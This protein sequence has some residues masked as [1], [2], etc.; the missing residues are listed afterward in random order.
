M[1]VLSWKQIDFYNLVPKYFFLLENSP[2]K[3]FQLM[4]QVHIL[5]YLYLIFSIV[6]VPIS[7]HKFSRILSGY[8]IIYAKYIH[9]SPFEKIP[10]CL[11]L[12]TP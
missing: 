4:N 8:N 11:S 12:S 10:R 6:P 5:P 3:I 7:P 1:N 9:H 2:Y